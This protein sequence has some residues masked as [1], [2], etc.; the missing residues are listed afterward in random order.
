[1][2]FSEQIWGKGERPDEA[3]LE[4]L[5]QSLKDQG[6]QRVFL[7]LKPG[8]SNRSRAKNSHRNHA[9]AWGKSFGFPQVYQCFFESIIA[10]FYFDPAEIPADATLPIRMANWYRNVR[11]FNRA[12]EPQHLTAPI[13]RRAWVKKGFVK[14]VREIFTD[15][16]I[17]HQLDVQWNL[18]IDAFLGVQKMAQIYNR[19]LLN[20]TLSDFLIDVWHPDGHFDFSDTKRI[21]KALRVRTTVDSTLKDLEEAVSLA[22]TA[23][24]SYQG[25][26]RA[27]IMRRIE[28][29]TY[30]AR[31]QYLMEHGIR[32]NF[33]VFM[34]NAWKE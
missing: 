17:S 13:P 8:E 7:S 12:A 1:M 11:S 14:K 28:K 25:L 18:F 34:R 22:S 29:R 3:A 10:A 33:D 21:V 24:E 15:R 27:E 23:A 6:V 16:V 2:H 5:A 26:S 32:T 20:L 19:E 4:A 9:C 31:M 30:A